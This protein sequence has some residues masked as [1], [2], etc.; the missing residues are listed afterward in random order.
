MPPSIRCRPTARQPALSPRI[1][2]LLIDLDDTLYPPGNGIW[3]L[4]SDRIDAYMTD[5]LGLSTAEAGRLRSSYLEAQGTT[6]QG[7]MRD[8]EIDPSGYLTFVHDLDYP[9]LLGPDSELRQVL[10]SLPQ[11]KYIFTNASAEHARNVLDALQLEDLFSGI[12]DIVAVDYANKPDRMAYVRALELIGGPPPEVCL[13]ADDRLVNLRSAHAMGMTTVL[14]GSGPGQD[15]DAQIDRLSELP[16]AL[17]HLLD[18]NQ[19]E[20]RRAHE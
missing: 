17:P 16:H 18:G 14:V 15:V 6:L 11:T 2:V 20:Q 1:E 9:S 3:R 13:L 10:E 4:I 12:I 8:Y 7:L 5:R 19:F